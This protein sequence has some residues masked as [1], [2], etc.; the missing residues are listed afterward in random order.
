MV[1]PTSC[2]AFHQY[3][4]RI[5]PVKVMVTLSL[6]TPCRNTV[7]AQVQ[8]HSFLTSIPDGNHSR[9]ERFSER[10]NLLLLPGF[11]HRTAQPTTSRYTYYAIPAPHFTENADYL[12]I[13][14]VRTPRQIGQYSLQPRTVEP[15]YDSR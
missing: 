11:E 13:L 7:G 4:R 3:G 9:S 12:A 8:L 6:S 5:S 1:R 14:F 10:E 15:Y 2:T